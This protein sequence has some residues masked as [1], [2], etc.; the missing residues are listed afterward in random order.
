MK[1]YEHQVIWLD[2]FNKNLSRKKGRKV[3]KDRA[4]FDPKIDEL[5]QATKA[6]GYN[7]KETNAEVN[8]PRRAY[9]R[10]G[11]ITVE[12]KHNKSKVINNIAERLLQQRNK[13]KGMQK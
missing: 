10:S 9:V 12:K 4:V 1:D 3:N 11:Y 7:P 6:A 13:V 2:Y 8:F 5:L